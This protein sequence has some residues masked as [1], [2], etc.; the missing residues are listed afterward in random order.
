ME[1]MKSL[2]SAKRET[3]IWDDEDDSYSM[4]AKQRIIGFFICLLIGVALSFLSFAFLFDPT[5]FALCYT[6]GNIVMLLS[7]AFM[8]GPVKQIKNM[9]APTRI[10]C[11][12]VFI[13]FMIFTIVCVFKDLPVIL[14]IISLLIQIAALVYYI[15]SYIPYGRSCIRNSFKGVVI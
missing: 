1:S 15:F 10:L 7:T 8:V 6:L 13:A 2:V 12:I 14:T 5:S 3:T 11:T 4:S 9:F